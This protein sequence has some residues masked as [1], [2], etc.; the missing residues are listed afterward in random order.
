MSPTSPLGSVARADS[1]ARTNGTPDSL[2]RCEVQFD[3]GKWVSPG[4]C[5]VFYIAA[6]ASFPVIDFEIHTS[7]PGPYDWTWEIRWIV[8]ACPQRRGRTRFK[9]RAPKM[10]TKGGSFRSNSKRWTAELGEIIGGE[11]VV[12]VTAGSER[13]VRRVHILGKEPGTDSINSELDRLS[14][15][16]PHETALARKI[17][18]QESG[19][20]HFYSDDMPLVSF[21][22][23]YGLGQATNPIPS[24]EQVWNWKAHVH[25]IVQAV[26][27]GKRASARRYL[28]SHGNYTDDHLD[29]E[30]LVYYNGANAHYYV[31]D[32]RS[33][34]WIVNGNVL[35]DPRQSNSGWDMR[36]CFTIWRMN[37]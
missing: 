14:T 25:Y 18:Q 30:T 5:A 7:A 1:A 33:G 6:D 16:Y 9:P 2:V 34:R 15:A 19:Y 22:N 4:S 21:D 24:Y 29:T 37:G 10:Y 26:I 32:V 36:N 23:G 17:F 28:D 27:H 35:C 31:W 13:F 8:K 11:L 3:R 12:T 20:S